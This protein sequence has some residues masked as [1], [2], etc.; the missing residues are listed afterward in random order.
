MKTSDKKTEILDCAQVLIQKRGYNGFSYADISSVVGIRKASIHHHF[1]TK[2]DLAV[3]VVVRYSEEF[4][5]HLL[6]IG[7]QKK[8]MEKIVF[9]ARLYQ[10]V[11]DE[12]KLC[13]CGML[14][15]D[16]ETLPEKVKQVVCRFLADN[17]NWLAAVL[18]VNHPQL[19]Q[20]RLLNI[21]WEIINSLQGGIIMARVLEDPAVFSAACEEMMLQ[22]Q[23][24][25]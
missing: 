15:A 16:R 18:A 6:N 17:A 3:A 2:E 7:V 19:S 14:A 13:L 22:L 1:P 5:L 20:K 4:N 11:L 21:A 24:I 8:G 9:Y 23:H 25:A 10:Q 12:D